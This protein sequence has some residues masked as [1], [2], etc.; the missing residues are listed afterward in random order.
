MFFYILMKVNWVYFCFGSSTCFRSS[1]DSMCRSVVGIERCDFPDRSARQATRAAWRQS[2]CVSSGGGSGASRAISA[3]SGSVSSSSSLSSLGPTRPC[4]AGPITADTRKQVEQVFRLDLGDGWF[5]CQGPSSVSKGPYRPLSPRVGPQAAAG[6]KP[7]QVIVSS[8]GSPS[9]SSDSQSGSDS[10]KHCLPSR[11]S[12]PAIRSSPSSNLR[13]SPSTT[14]CQT[15]VRNSPSTASGLHSSPSSATINSPGPKTSP[16]ITSLSRASPS[17]MPT[18]ASRA[19]SPAMQASSAGLAVTLNTTPAFSTLTGLQSTISNINTTA[20]NIYNLNYSQPTTYASTNPFLTGAY[21]NYTP[22]EISFSEKYNT[23]ASTKDNKPFTFDTTYQ[24]SKYSTLHSKS[25]YDPSDFVS[26]EIKYSTLGS[27]YQE[28]A[29]YLGVNYGGESKY[30]P[31]SKDS[32]GSS[33]DTS[34]NVT[35]SSMLLGVED[36]PTPTSS[37]ETEDS[38]TREVGE[39]DVEGDGEQSD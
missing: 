34:P 31:G 13:N 9:S 36:T 37:I 1:L 32:K 25:T 39:R 38:T 20:N 8:P 23:I 18:T 16:S 26:S 28:K 19:S 30:S 24:D 15:G 2:Q 10:V 7:R 22:G 4:A 12:S 14:I 35:Q 6:L 11:V 21:L 5:I 3:L 17:L 27:K 33:Y 29:G